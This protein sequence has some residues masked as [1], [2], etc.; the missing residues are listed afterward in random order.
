MRALE[1]ISSMGL[2]SFLM[3]ARKLQGSGG[4]LALCGLAGPVR[5]VFRIA[6]L[7]SIFSVFESPE[8]ALARSS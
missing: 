4:R 2:R 8:A 1:Y 3:L 7:L 6:G 5:E